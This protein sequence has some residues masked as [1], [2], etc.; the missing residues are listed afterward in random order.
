MSQNSLSFQVKSPVQALT[1]LSRQIALPHEFAPERFPSFPALERTAVMGFNYPV[2]ATVPANGHFRAM[3]MRQAA[4]PLWGDRTITGVMAYQ[5]TYSWKAG[6]GSGTVVGTFEVD[7]GI[8]GAASNNCNATTACVGMSG[9]GAA[10]AYPI[11]GTDDACSGPPFT[12]VGNNHYCTVVLNMGVANSGTFQVQFER[13]LGPGDVVPYS[14]RVDVVIAAGKF[15]GTASLS[16]TSVQSAWLRP[17]SI[18]AMGASVFPVSTAQRTVALVVHNAAATFADSATNAGTLSFAGGL[19]EPNFM[20]LLAPTE[21]A[22][23][24]LPWAGTRVTAVASLFTNVTQVLNKGGTVLCG[25]LNPRASNVYDWTE[26]DLTGLHP[27]EKAYLPF[28]TGAYSYCPPSTDLVQFL[29]YTSTA[30]TVF[31]SAT[32]TSTGYIPVVRLDND[33]LV[34]CLD[35][36]ATSEAETIAINCDLHV[37]FRTSS[38]LFQIGMSPVTIETLHQAQLALASIGFFFPNSGHQSILNRVINAAKKMLPHLVAGAKKVAPML[39]GPAGKIA[40]LVLSN[41]PRGSMVTTTGA[42]SGIV[43]KPTAGV[44]KKKAKTSVKSKKNKK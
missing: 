1:G 10:I 27:A 28:E 13:W 7:P 30:C 23:S 39:P 33:A 6:D 21:F 24:T 2:S 19:S 32:T 37:E 43:V 5:N 25:R 9:I 12:Y 20:P 16:M 4:Y 36:K 31:P 29:D 34:C 35:F 17:V 44:R 38:A 3:V 11:L 42:R 26:S 8:I 14:A 40:S 41:V 15:S 18:T 22:T